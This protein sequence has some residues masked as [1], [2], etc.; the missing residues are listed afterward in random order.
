MFSANSSQQRRDDDA[1]DRVLAV[2]R[3]VWDHVVSPGWLDGP[4]D[5]RGNIKRGPD[6]CRQ[7]DLFRAAE[8][9]FPIVGLVCRRALAFDPRFG[10]YIGSYF[11][12]QTAASVPA[13]SCAAWILSNRHV[14][15]RID[16]DI[17]DL[18]SAPYS[19]EADIEATSTSSTSSG[20]GG[21]DSEG[22][23]GEG[24]RRVRG[25]GRGEDF[26]GVD[27]V[28]KEVSATVAGLLM[29]GHVGLA[30]TLFGGGGDHSEEYRVVATTSNTICTLPRL[31]DGRRVASW[32]TACHTDCG[33]DDGTMGCRWLVDVLGIGMKEAPLVMYEPMRFCVYDGKME[34]V[35]WLFERFGF[36]SNLHQTAHSEL[37]SWCSM[38]S[39]P[40]NLKWFNVA[41]LDSTSEEYVTRSLVS[42]KHS[43]VEDCKWQPWVERYIRGGGYTDLLEDVH[44][45][46][47]VKWLVTTLSSQPG[48]D[49]LNR[50][51]KKTGDVELTQWL[52]TEHK[53]TP[54][55]ATFES[56]CSTPRKKGSTLARWL[57]PRVSLS[58]TNIIKSLVSALIWG[59]MEVA[60]WLDETFHVM[61]AVNSNA[62]VAESCLVEICTEL[63][64]YKDKVVGL[65]W[66]LQHLSAPDHSGISM[67]CIHKAIS[68]ALPYRTNAIALLLETFPAVEP[69]LDQAQLEKIVSQFMNA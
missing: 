19:G 26:V 62:E 45:P 24:G 67:S 40:G 58:Q 49:D 18:F 35:K 10:A 60:E 36:G 65:E 14:R 17:G 57:S 44:N 46:E 42:N 68:Q 37:C 3:L 1:I 29:G 25:Y 56:A 9:M 43:T 2:S 61:D 39:C 15:G 20:V 33:A 11:A 48:E 16:N 8:A 64:D 6:G 31:W 34:V 50:I 22:S 28:V 23:I 21:I 13:P 27:V 32:E 54:T 69:L 12:I 53:F 47:V 59:N 63:G 51:C 52:V 30:T 55:A 5:S 41:L 38:G 4:R 66:F 7:W